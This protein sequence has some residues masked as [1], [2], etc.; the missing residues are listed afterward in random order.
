MKQTR[1]LMD[2]PADVYT[3]SPLCMLVKFNRTSWNPRCPCKHL[4]RF[5]SLS[6]CKLQE[7][8]S[9]SAPFC[10]ALQ[11]AWKSTQAPG[12]SPSTH[13]DPRAPVCVCGGRGVG[14]GAGTW[15]GV[16]RPPSSRP[17][18]WMGAQDAS[19]LQ[20]ARGQSKAKY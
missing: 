4:R 6:G 16:G 12:P 2:P 7:G 9:G 8:R 14:V 18:A 13:L 19:S 5:P 11:P 1:Q 3:E 20:A 10:R 17:R 15:A